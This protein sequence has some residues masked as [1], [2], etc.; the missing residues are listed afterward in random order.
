[1]FRT[2]FV[3]LAG[4]LVLAGCNDK[5][6]TDKAEEKKAEATEAAVTAPATDNKTSDMTEAQKRSYALGA[7]SAGFLTRS[8]PEFDS[9]GMSVDKELIKKGFV[10]M[11][12]N[13]SELSTEEMQTILLALQKEIQEKIAAIEAEKAEKTL[14]A[15]KTFMDAHAQEE[16]V[17]VTE[18]G[19]QYKILTEGTGANPT[20][21]DTVRVHYRGTLID[22]TE[23]DSSY[24]RG[25]PIDFQVQRVIK[26][27]AEGIQLVKE[28]G[29]IQLVM[30]PDLGYGAQ[31]TPTIPGNSAL[32]FEVELLKINPEP[33]PAAPTEG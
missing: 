15:N 1:M 2:L 28:G 5:S 19:L 16:G 18:S 10:D 12:E 11:L 4:V 27:W 29:K 26:G 22:G 7:N 17:K 32:I 24:K 25:Q 31:D 14:A 30:G 33:E 13:K 9:W 20:A 21:T 3:L 23:F 6:A 8:F